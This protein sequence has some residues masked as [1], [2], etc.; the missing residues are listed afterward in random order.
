M[1]VNYKY[2]H[3]TGSI[4]G[5]ILKSIFALLTQDSLGEKYSAAF[6]PQVFPLTLKRLRGW[7]GGSFWTSDFFWITQKRVEIFPGGGRG[8]GELPNVMYTGMCHWPGS[9]F[10]LQKS[11]TGPKFL[12]FY[13]R[14]G[15]TFWSFT[16]E[17]DPFLAIWS[18]MPWLKCQKSQLRLSFVSCSLM[19]SFLFCKVFQA[20]YNWDQFESG[21]MYSSL[22]LTWFH[23]CG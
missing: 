13:S 7:E 8:G 10:D 19:S 1:T 15:P 5:P 2:S 17:Q 18:P 22:N 9:I 12:K 3:Y 4:S 20:F 6:Y 11:R 14:T 23:H 16:P 21:H